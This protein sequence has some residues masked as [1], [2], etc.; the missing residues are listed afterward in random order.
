MARLPRLVVPH[1]PHLISQQ[2]ID[3]QPVF[4]DTDDH[5]NFLAWLREGAKLFKVAIH[6]YVLLPDRL[7]I[8]AT[9]A[10]ATGLGRMMQWVG[11]H[12]VPYFNKKHGRAG[13]LWQGRF[14]AAVLDADRYL[15]AGSRY[16]ESRPV[17]AGLAT[18]VTEYPWSSCAHHVGSRSDP[19]ISDHPAYWSLGNTP[20]EREA[21]YRALLER[22][23]TDE[24]IV[25]LQHAA[26]TGWA[27]G[28]DTFKARLE[29]SS[30]RRLTPAKRGR[31]VKSLTPSPIK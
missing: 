22:A 21:A 7:A 1:H 9:P 30:R 20:F 17:D 26:T 4:R 29:K 8:L 15:I 18:D 16:L 13:T 25:S 28:S 14:K 23:L 10:D 3:R 12:Y 24:E 2:G 19:L 11:R 27:V 6:A 5:T 31:P